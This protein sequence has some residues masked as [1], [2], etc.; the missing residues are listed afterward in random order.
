MT[1]ANTVDAI[2]L[3]IGRLNKNVT[4]N[5]IPEAIAAKG[6][7]FLT[8]SSFLSIY[9][10]YNLQ[11]SLFNISIFNTQKEDKFNPLYGLK[12]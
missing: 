4:T 5:A 7:H 6:N 8:A 10:V 1:P 11:N 9:L 3:S 2:T 12:D